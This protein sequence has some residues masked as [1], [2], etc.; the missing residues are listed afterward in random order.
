MACGAIFPRLNNVFPLA[1]LIGSTPIRKITCRALM[2]R[3]MFCFYLRQLYRIHAEERDDM[4]CD[5]A[6]SYVVFSQAARFHCASQVQLN[7][8]LTIKRKIDLTLSQGY[9]FRFT[10]FQDLLCNTVVMYSYMNN[11]YNQ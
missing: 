3:S 4:Q 6:A 10:L 11:N 2:P 7:S 8:F 9:F 1:R 5:V